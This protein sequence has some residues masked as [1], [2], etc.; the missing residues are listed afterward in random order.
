MPVVAQ[1]ARIKDLTTISGVR[2]NP[3]VGYG[4]V[5]GLDGT[6]D[7]EQ[8]TKQ[9][10]ITMLD[11]MG[12]TLPPGVTPSAKNV[13]AVALHAE[14]PAFSKAGQT[15]DVT[16]SSLGNAKS[17]RGG[18]LLMAP[19]RGADGAVYAVAQGNLVVG[20]FGFGGQDGSNIKMNV[21][22]VG[23]IPNGA[24]VEKVVETDFAER[25]SLTFNLQNSDFTLSRKVAERINAFAGDVTAVPIDATS[26]VVNMPPDITERVAFISAVE[27]LELELP[28]QRARVIVNSRTG[29]VIIGQNVE[30]Q[31]TAIS[32]GSLTVT[33]NEN[34][35]VSQPGAFSN[36]QTAVTPSSNISVSQEKKPMFIFNPGISLD[37]VIKAVNEVGVSPE[38]L[39]AILD[40]LKQAGALQAD[41]EII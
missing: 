23:R 9:S 3:L 10:F 4:L 32:H 7:N 41:L 20:G 37:T 33:I 1:A 6:G 5:V 17:L 11:Q 34:L 36:G 26:V 15:I 12:I 13:A 27:N 19:L 25:A 21:P 29:T 39:V 18:T 30:V 40:G 28:T 14:L 38:D 8:F 22:S 2:G 31:P 16:V 24:M 35:Q